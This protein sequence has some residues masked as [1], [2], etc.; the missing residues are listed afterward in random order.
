VKNRPLF[1]QSHYYLDVSPAYFFLFPKFRIVLGG[2]DFFLVESIQGGKNLEHRT[3]TPS[4]YFMECGKKVDYAGENIFEFS[5]AKFYTFFILMF[6]FWGILFIRSFIHTLL[7]NLKPELTLNT[8]EKLSS[9]FKVHT[10][11]LH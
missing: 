11:F 10:L 6:R 9:Y 5:K 3:Q 8:N 1:P 4:K 2:R 7:N